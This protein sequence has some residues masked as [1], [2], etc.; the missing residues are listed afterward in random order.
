LL[1]I[2]QG[3]QIGFANLPYTIFA[4]RLDPAQL[5]RY[6]GSL[7][8]FTLAFGGLIVAL[9]AFGLPLLNSLK[10]GRQSFPGGA[11]PVLAA[12]FIA[13]TVRDLNRSVLLAE[14]RIMDS[15]RISL[16]SSAGQIF[17]AL[18]LFWRDWLTLESAFGIVALANAFAAIGMLT[19]KGISWRFERS[20]LHADLYRSL[21][22][23][24]WNAAGTATYMISSQ[25]YPWLILAL[26]GSSEVAAFGVCSSIANLPGALLRGVSAYLLP[27]MS[28]G[29][30]GWDR[31]ALQRL[32]IKSVQVF[33]IACLPWVIIGAV[34]AESLTVFFYSKKYE[35]YSKLFVWLL[36][37]YAAESIGTPLTT[38]LQ[39]LEK[40][41][42]VAI[43]GAIGAGVTLLLGPLAISLMGLNG[44][45]LAALVS[46]IAMIAYRWVAFRRVGARASAMN[47]AR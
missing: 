5:S 29:F 47:I 35:G 39:A 32:L 8:A 26:L 36:F 42:H 7:L 12:C 22:I 21:N 6:R 46:T 3:F 4:P 24:K 25:L 43:S 16:L 1:L 33:L 44:A 27:R 10:D 37:K 34:F 9:L 20:T 45:G 14:L 38:A 23:A 30:K 11:I 40:V 13:L 41:N 17:A 28:Q 18:V 15:L 2:F 19:T 31:K